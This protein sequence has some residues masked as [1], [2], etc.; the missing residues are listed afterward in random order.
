VL[1]SS[2]AASRTVRWIRY[3]TSVPVNGV[4]L[5]AVND[6]PVAPLN[7]SSAGRSTPAVT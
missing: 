3:S 1:V 7:S 4:S 5:A 6:P 2:P